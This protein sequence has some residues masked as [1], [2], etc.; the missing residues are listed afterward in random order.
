MMEKDGGNNRYEYT[1]YNA[2]LIITTG[3]YGIDTRVRRMGW[4]R[5]WWISV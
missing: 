1:V 3:T 5:E 2:L 4:A